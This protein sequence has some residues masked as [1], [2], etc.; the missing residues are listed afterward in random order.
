MG[1]QEIDLEVCE[2]TLPEQLE[3]GLH[4]PD[5]R[6]LPTELDEAHAWGCQ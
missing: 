2:V 5:R 6:D 3:H 1:L 4:H